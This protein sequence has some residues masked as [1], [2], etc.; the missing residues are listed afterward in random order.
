MARPPEVTR[1]QVTRPLARWREGVRVS[2]AA[3]AETGSLTP[4]TR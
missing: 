1:G 4:A 2:V 3:E